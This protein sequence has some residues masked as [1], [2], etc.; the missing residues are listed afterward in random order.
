[1]LCIG[2]RAT[3]HTNFNLGGFL[4]AACH[5]ASV[6]PPFP[7]GSPASSTVYP[8]HPTGALNENEVGKR[9]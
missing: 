2:K 4:P 3:R 8:F 6:L 5:G 9:P 1:M 7:L